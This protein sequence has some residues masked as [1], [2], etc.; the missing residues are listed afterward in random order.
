M[1]IFIP[2]FS[3]DFYHL[4]AIY[5]HIM[6]KRYLKVF[7]LCFQSK[8]NAQK[9]KEAGVTIGK[10]WNDQKK[11]RPKNGRNSASP[12]STRR[13][14]MKIHEAEESLT[15]RPW[16]LSDGL[17]ESVIDLASRVKFINTAFQIDTMESREPLGRKAAN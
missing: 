13:V 10:F 7:E 4:L 1:C 5:L 14:A 6:D 16:G 8:R 2:L 17:D 11:K 3:I 15:F 9:Q 12:A